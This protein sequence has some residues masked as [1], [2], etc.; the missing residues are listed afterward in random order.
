MLARD[1]FSAPAIPPAVQGCYR[2][3]AQALTASLASVPDSSFD[4]PVWHGTTFW[5]GAWDYLKYRKTVD[6]SLQGRVYLR[7]IAALC[8]E[9]V[10]ISTQ[11]TP[12]PTI[13]Q[14][15]G[16]SCPFLDDA[17]RARLQQVSWW[18]FSEVCELQG[19]VKPGRRFALKRYR[20]HSIPLDTATMR[21][22]AVRACMAAGWDGSAPD[23]VQAEVP[24][25]PHFKPGSIS[26]IFEQHAN[27]SKA[28]GSARTVRPDTS[29]IAP[30]PQSETSSSECKQQ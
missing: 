25:G 5:P 17:S 26:R 21:A 8:A 13:T 27:R 6:K 24:Q 22:N 12:P 9:G 14:Y 1:K 19:G 15:S 23:A 10:N 2:N 28:G 18:H 7:E 20:I 4:P 11:P 3:L 29:W 30:T 16:T